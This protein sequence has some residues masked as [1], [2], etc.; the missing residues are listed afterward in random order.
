MSTNRVFMSSPHHS[1]NW[2]RS[3]LSS[4]YFDPSQAKFRLCKMFAFS[5]HSSSFRAHIFF[6]HKVMAA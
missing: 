6:Q 3:E 5:V 4:A 1:E 2:S